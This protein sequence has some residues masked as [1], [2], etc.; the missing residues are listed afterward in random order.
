MKGHTTTTATL[1]IPEAF[2][3]LLPVGEY[4]TD[5]ETIDGIQAIFIYTNR[6]VSLLLPPQLH[7]IFFSNCQPKSWFCDRKV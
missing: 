2:K 5:L 7:G 4:E 6:P 3:G 1:N